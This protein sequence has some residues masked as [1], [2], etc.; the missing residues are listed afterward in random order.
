MGYST[1][2]IN[3]GVNYPKRKTYDPTTS[4]NQYYAGK[5]WLNINT[6]Q[7][8]LCTECNTG[9]SAT[10]VSISGK[11]DPS[12]EKIIYG[13]MVGE[14]QYNLALQ[15]AAFSPHMKAMQLGSNDEMEEGITGT[16]YDD[17]VLNTSGLFWIYD[18]ID[19]SIPQVSNIG[20][21]PF[22]L[23][24]V[25]GRL[26]LAAGGLNYCGYAR[27]GIT[28]LKHCYDNLSIYAKPDTANL[29]DLLQDIL[30]A[31]GLGSATPSQID[32]DANISNFSSIFWLS[33]QTK[34]EKICNFPSIRKTGN[35]GGN[36]LRFDPNDVNRFCFDTTAGTVIPIET[37]HPT[38]PSS[39]ITYNYAGV[40]GYA[41]I[42]LGNISVIDGTSVGTTNKRREYLSNLITDG[43]PERNKYGYLGFFLFRDILFPERCII[44]IKPLT[45]DT[46]TVDYL[47]RNNDWRNKYDLEALSVDSQG[48]MTPFGAI[49]GTRFN[50]DLFKNFITPSMRSSI[51]RGHNHFPKI[52]FRYRDKVTGKVGRISNTGVTINF[53]EKGGRVPYRLRT[54]QGVL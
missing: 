23:A 41:N 12:P 43:T 54:I 1:I 35:P 37:G 32:F 47:V 5:L 28:S 27:G 25:R 19:N 34:G 48:R 33:H 51:F 14:A 50:L 40:Y 7:V 2:P 39:R 18:E 10:W 31:A 36:S 42:L 49:T 46:I 15:G 8:F 30:S 45:C 13:N 3:I 4:D 52:F 9:S 24:N 26:K 11:K 44:Q 16:D 17:L 21:Y 38:A 6:D 22:F 29:R 20:I 53:W